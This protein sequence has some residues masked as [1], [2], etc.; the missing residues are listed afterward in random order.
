[1]DAEKWLKPENLKKVTNWAKKENLSI[2][3][4]AKKMRISAR[5]FYRW[6]DK[7][8][9]F[10]EAFDEGRETVDGTVETSFI[11]MCIGF[12]ETVTKPQK[13]KRVVYE[14]GKKVEEYEE[15]ID[16]Q[17]E[18]YIKPDVTAQKFYLTNRKPGAWKTDTK[19]LGVVGDEDNTGVVML[20]EVEEP[21]EVVEAEIV[22]SDALQ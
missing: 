5:T 7:Y 9:E 13:I 18:V 14:D 21:G 20:P 12:K 8:E 10:R 6:L 11:K 22:Q 3:Q 4:I 2:A 15:F 19:E 17:E 16:V 1:M